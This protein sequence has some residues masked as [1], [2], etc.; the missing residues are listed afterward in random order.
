MAVILQTMLNGEVTAMSIR[1]LKS[2]TKEAS[3]AIVRNGI[4]SAASILV[5][6]AC[7]LLFGV[8][9]IITINVNYIGEQIT[10][11]C[12][13]QVYIDDNMRDAANIER[14]GKEIR[15]LENVESAQHVTGKQTFDEFKNDLTA[16]ELTAYEAVPETIISDSF[17][18]ILADLSLAGDVA[19]KA[20]KIE[21]VSRVNNHEN[22]I[23][24]VETLSRVIRHVSVWVV[25]FFA[26]ISIFIISNTIKLTVHNRRREI[27]I[28]KYIGATDSFIRWPFVVEGV[29]VGLIGATVAFIATHIGYAVLLG[30]ISKISAISSLIK[31]K[32]FGDMF[33]ILLLTYVFLGFAIGSVGSAVSIRKYLKV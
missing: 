22:E 32:T 15:S 7:L 30:Q 1:T 18:V 11:Q 13:L 27:N 5:V 8:F 24:T 4:M 2:A 29:I 16:E 3:K 6:G 19:D 9:M 12:Q 10:N 26:L 14:I 23:A 31:L 20:E 25:L 33:G 21:G 17:K 28:M